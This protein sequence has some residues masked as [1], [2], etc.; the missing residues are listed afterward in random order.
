MH[1]HEPEAAH[2]ESDQRQVATPRHRARW[3]V[4]AVA[5]VLV[6]LGVWFVWG[7]MSIRMASK[8]AQSHLTDAQEAM[9]KD[10][11]PGARA[12]VAG[13]YGDLESARSALGSTPFRI[14]GAAPY[15]SVPV[16]DVQHLIEAG[17]S[18]VQASDALVA[19]YASVAGSEGASALFSNGSVNLSAIPTLVTAVKEAKAD[20][21]AAT[22]SLDEVQGSFPG[23]SSLSESAIELRAAVDPLKSTINAVEG[24]LPDLPAALGVTRPARYLIAILNNGEMRASGGAPLSLAVI[25][26]DNGRLRVVERGQTSTQIIPGNPPIIWDHISSAPFARTSK[27]DRFVNSNAHPDFR[28]AGEEMLRAWEASGKQPV[29]GVIALDPNAIVASLRATG[30]VTSPGFG[31]VTADNFVGKWVK[32]YEDFDSTGDRQSINDALAGSLIDRITSGKGLFS[33]AGALAGVAPGRHFQIYL[34]T[35][36]LQNAIEQAS[37]AG[38]VSTPDGGDHSAWYSLNSNA[39]KT[40][41]FSRRTLTID[42]HVTSDGGATVTQTMSVKNST[43]DGFGDDSIAGYLTPWN[44]SRFVAYLPAGAETPSMDHPAGWSADTVWTDGLGRSLMLS[45]GWIAPRATAVLTLTYRLPAGTF[46]GGVYRLTIDPQGVLWP[47]T[48][49]VQVSRDGGDSAQALPPTSLTRVIR[50]E[51]RPT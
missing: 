5:L 1:E 41:V 30:P 48:V 22:Q 40:D 36:S 13:A 34:R 15:L 35:P 38:E 2:T 44:R 43:P 37:L 29:D 24:A 33:L 46:P 23:T 7:V 32:S 27:P 16:A 42:A 39:S 10:D 31:T 12:G 20:L 45:G 21:A 8:S 11:V 50:I 28:I 6:V 19:A 25:E 51:N 26:F 4:G 49:S 3:M 18:A 14:L 17:E 47:V 9:S